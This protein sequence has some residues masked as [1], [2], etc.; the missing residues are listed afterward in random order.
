PGTYFLVLEGRRNAGAG[1]ASYTFNVVP[2]AVTSTPLT[3]GN[4]VNGNIS[5]PGESDDYTFTLAGAARLAF[6]SLVDSGTIQWSLTGPAGAVLVS[7]RSFQG[8]DSFDGDPILNLAAGSYVLT[9]DGV[10]DNTG[11]YSFRLL[12]LASATAVT[13][14]TPVSSDFTPGNETDLYKFTLANPATLY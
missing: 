12:N 11:S 14:G 4:T 1:S 9:A 5:V 10:N 2:D 6:D 13:P 3:L 7:N 8:S